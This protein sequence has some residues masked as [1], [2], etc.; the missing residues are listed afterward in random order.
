VLW[1]FARVITSVLREGDMLFRYGGEEFVVLLPHTGPDG[2]L[3]AARRMVAETASA[4]LHVSD[5]SIPVTTSTGVA[6]LELSTR[7]GAELATKADRALYEA[8]EGGRNRA[9]ANGLSF[10]PGVAGRAS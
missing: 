4:P 9:V 1:S 8:K 2:A 3:S 5:G 10:V 7:D 6:S